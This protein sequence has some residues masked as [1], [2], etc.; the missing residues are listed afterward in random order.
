MKNP[1]GKACKYYYGD[2][3]RGR[4]VQT[5]RLIEQNT[6]SRPWHPGICVKCTVPDILRANATDN[7]K[8]DVT[9]K[10][11][12]FGFQEDVKVE[13]WCSEC[14]AAVPDP[15]RGCPNCSQNRPSIF[16]LPQTPS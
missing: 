7:L 13:G 1:A 8:L 11:K 4:D 5:C 12:W 10:S 15:I 9:V 14:F 16:D 2:F 3:H 6:E